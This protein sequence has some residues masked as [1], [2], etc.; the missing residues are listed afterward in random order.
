MNI[1]F[2]DT[3]Y[4]EHWIHPNPDFIITNLHELVKNS[5]EVIVILP[6]YME[7]RRRLLLRSIRFRPRYYHDV[8]RSAMRCAN[9]TVERTN[10]WVADVMSELMG[11][12]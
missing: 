3:D 5:Q 8:L 7:F 2:N 6:S 4:Y 10:N 9:C 1:A 12:G 11:S